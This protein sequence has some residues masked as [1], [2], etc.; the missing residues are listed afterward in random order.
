LEVASKYKMYSWLEWS[1]KIL[2]FGGLSW[3]IYDRVWKMNSELHYLEN[4]S[5]NFSNGNSLYLLFC[6]LLSP[7]NWLLEARKWSFLTSV[8]QKLSWKN[9]S[10]S[11]FAGITLGILT[12]SR[13]GEYG[14]RLLH[15]N[16]LNRSKAIYAYFLSSLSQN[17][18]IILFGSISVITYFSK[19][20]AY[21][22]WASFSF[23]VLMLL[24]SC[25]LLF[26]FFQN[27]GV[28]GLIKK[29]PFL[30]KK[31]SSVTI[32]GYDASILSKVLSMSTIR[33]VI[34][35][36]QYVILL[37]YFNIDVS[38]VEAFIGVC[39]IY[40]FQSGLPL[41]PALSLIARAELAL[42]IWQAYD[43]DKI[44]ILSVPILLWVIN[45]LIPG[46]IGGLIILQTNFKNLVKD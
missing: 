1:I 26:I 30:N 5:H 43:T 39:V 28:W 37:N 18:P 21:S 11:I 4:I 34:Y 23:G 40:L 17:I 14:G 31:L 41:P 46:L 24:L 3:L 13:L 16:S 8:F 25:L 22:F 20:Y 29:I 38:V 10:E 19:N 36:S 15:I 9:I 2:V 35:L 44:A 33:Y 42:I 7:L 45:L 27:E 32:I 6:V 12:P